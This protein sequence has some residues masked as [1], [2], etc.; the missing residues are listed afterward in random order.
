MYVVLYIL[1]R[2][3]V[4]QQSVARFSLEK[5]AVLVL[6]GAVFLIR[7]VPLQFTNLPLGSDPSF[8]L[9]IVEKILREARLPLTW[10]PFES[11]PLHYSTGL[12]VF[13]AFVAKISDVPSHQVFKLG[14]A[15]APALCAGLIYVL[16]ERVGRSSKIAFWSAMSWAFL[17]FW[18]GLEY[19]SW[20]GLPT[21][22]GMTLALGLFYSMLELNHRLAL[23]SHAILLSTIVFVHN[24]SGLSVL[25]VLMAYVFLAY[26][27]ER[28]IN[29]I[30]RN[31]VATLLGS[32]L[33]GAHLVFK[34]LKDFFLMG[35]DTELFRFYEGVLS[36]KDIIQASGTYYFIA[37]VLGLFVFIRNMRTEEEFF[38]LSWFCSLLL[39]FVALEYVYR[40]I[41]F[42]LYGESYTAL[43]PSRFLTIMAFPG[44]LFAGHACHGFVGKF[45]KNLHQRVVSMVLLVGMLSYTALV[46]ERQARPVTEVDFSMMRWLRENT[47]ED[48]FVLNNHKW[49]SYLTWREGS[50]TELPSVETKN[51]PSVVFKVE[52]LKRFNEFRKW[53]ETVSRPIYRLEEPGRQLAS[54]FKEVFRTE[55]T[56]LYVWE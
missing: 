39:M 10:M 53:Q 42:A 4:P 29:G 7:M 38:W 16:A 56:V 9:I 12:H 34:H 13:V 24:H 17:A 19:G 50:F 6:V 11:I 26:V 49:S 33:F 44:A 15:L 47:S 31:V 20:G 21:L 22:A 3:F 14:F 54:R 37:L 35:R 25:L 32:I 1:S 30:S 43:T 2:S 8:H 23:V 55:K 51:A 36:F 45:S 41:V 27:V 5:D 48:A 46:L 28:N 52:K 18:G 40:F